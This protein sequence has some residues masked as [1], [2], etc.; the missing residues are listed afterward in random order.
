MGVAVQRPRAPHS[1]TA[2]RLRLE[3]QRLLLGGGALFAGYYVAFWLLGIYTLP[4]LG[5]GL[6]MAA[7]LALAGVLTRRVDARGSQVVAMMVAVLLG[8]G[9]A[10]SALFSGG[11]RCVGFHTLWALPLIYGLFVRDAW[12]GSATIGV[13]SLLG[14]LGV[15]VRDETDA[16]RIVQWVTLSV[17]AGVFAFVKQ[18]F[19]RRNLRLTLEEMESTQLRLAT[20]DRMASVG[21][22]AAGVAHEINN[23]MSYVGTNVDFA[24]KRIAEHLER[25][26]LPAD[27]EID[28]ALADARNGCDRVSGIV[29]TLSRLSHER[30]AGVGDVD[31]NR[32]LSD[33]LRLSR[34]R[35]DAVAT[36]RFSPGDV[37]PIAGDEARLGQAVLNLLVNSAHAVEARRDG[38]RTIELATFSRGAGEVVVEVRDTGSGIA[39]EVLPR[40]FEPFFTTKPPGKGTGLGLAVC[41]EIVREHRGHIEVQSTLGEGTVFRVVLPRLGVEP[42]AP[43]SR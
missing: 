43:P 33:V 25:S 37:G 21:L 24:R 16:S 10:L 19:E 23:P 31:L 2:E 20:A 15:L 8:V 38:P 22:L 18:V 39:A 5:V 17:A 4:S 32:A 11:S 7:G 14:G 42:G 34:R 26:G 12:A 27:E 3:G 29:S 1:P 41:A 30:G 13:T 28:E 9:A 36:V 6:T 35:L 40:I